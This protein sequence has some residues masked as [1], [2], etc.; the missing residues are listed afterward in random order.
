MYLSYQYFHSV[1]IDKILRFIA[2]TV[3]LFEQNCCLLHKDKHIHSG[4]FKVMVPI[5]I[6]SGLCNMYVEKQA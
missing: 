3:H 5:D 6:M 1:N 4:C 2:D